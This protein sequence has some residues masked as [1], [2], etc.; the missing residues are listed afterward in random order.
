M[1]YKTPTNLSM[2]R[3]SSLRVALEREGDTSS[4]KRE[5]IIGAGKK[6]ERGRTVATNK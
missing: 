1:E 6:V 2:F 5:G 4:R 3:H